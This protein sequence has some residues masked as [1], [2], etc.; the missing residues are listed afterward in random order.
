MK[1]SDNKSFSKQEPP[2]PGDGFKYLFPIL[3]S[4]YTIDLTSWTSQLSY[5]SHNYVTEF[6]ALILWASMAFA[7][8]FPSSE[9][10]WPTCITLEHLCNSLIWTKAACPNSSLGDP[11]TTLSGFSKFLM[12][13]PTAKNSGIDKTITWSPSISSTNLAVPIGTVDLLTMIFLPS[14]S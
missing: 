11:M 7:S 14:Q 12:A 6:I 9:E 4:A 2:K 8:N 10:A 3:W 13:Y 1:M 5:C